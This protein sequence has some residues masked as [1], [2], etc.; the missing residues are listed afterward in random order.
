[1][2]RRH[3]M[4]LSALSSLSGMHWLSIDLRAGST[5]TQRQGHRY[6]LRYAPRLD[7]LRE[8]L[9][10]DQRLE[11]FAE[12][13][14]DATE[15]N[16]LLRHPMA[17]VEKMRKKLD[18]L[19]MQMGIFVANPGGWTTAGLCHPSQ[20]DN[21]LGEIR[22]AVGYHRVIGNNF[23]TVLTGP[24]RSQLSRNQQRQNVIEGLK[25]AADILESTELTIVIEPL[26]ELVN[27]PGYFL[28]Y[29]EEAAQIMAAV[30]SPHVKILFDAY[31]QQISEGNLIANIREY[32][33]YIGYYQV[34][35]VPGRKEPGTGEVNWKNV[36]KAIHGTG[37]RG[38]VGME[39][40]LSQPG[41][42]GLMKCFE[43]YRQADSW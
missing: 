37:Y 23:C 40:G 24:V 22:K 38:I 25:R 9:S 8:E 33:Q 19:G 26:N 18:S 36:F 6:H 11:L 17:E 10:I 7:F 28:V 14:F 16:G 4:K 39:H 35:D 42:A 43:E 2:Y 1:M 21:F 30:D 15:Y 29:S 3:F 32:Q 20:R 31:H 12:H 13:G 27:H 5:G 41:H 34:G